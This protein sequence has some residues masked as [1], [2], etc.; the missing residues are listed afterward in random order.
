M[1]A[2]ASHQRSSK[3]QTNMTRFSW[4]RE[5][6]QHFLVN[7]GE[8]SAYPHVCA[9]VTS[10]FSRVWLSVTLWTVARQSMDRS[11]V[12]GD[13][14]GKNNAVDY[15]ASSRGSSRPRDGTWISYVS[16]ID[17]WALS[18][19]LAPPGKPTYSRG[20]YSLLEKHTTAYTQR[21]SNWGKSTIS[22]ELPQLP[23]SNQ[24]AILKP[25]FSISSTN[26]SGS[27]VRTGQR[28]VSRTESQWTN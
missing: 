10:R 25:L 12:H 18:L 16:C 3:Q 20:V 15:H 5:E 27:H 13:P 8:A 28:Q 9:C 23:P 6:T 2:I 7:S 22:M 14:P 4:L 17:R 1:K 21:I 11:S 26:S 19:P 24:T